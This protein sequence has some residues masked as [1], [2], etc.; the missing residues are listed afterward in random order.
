MRCA[1]VSEREPQRTDARRNGVKHLPFLLV[2]A[3]L[4]GPVSCGDD[5]RSAAKRTAATSMPAN[6]ALDDVRYECGAAD[7]AVITF[8]TR[9]HHSFSGTAELVIG[10]QT[11]G[12]TDATAGPAPR[13]FTMDIDL[14]KA[15]YD[16]GR[17]TVQAT[18]P[19][20]DVAASAPVVFRL[21]PAASCG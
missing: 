7:G 3:V 6:V 16:A 9:A 17:G 4:I 18:S 19:N 12:R 15:A 13:T 11:Y 20:G 1:A 8:R 14:P 5:H 10:D 21:A 2:A